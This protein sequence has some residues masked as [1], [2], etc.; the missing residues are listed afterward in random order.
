MWPW[1]S[2]VLVTLPF[3]HGP[4]PT[5]PRFIYATQDFDKQHVLEEAIEHDHIGV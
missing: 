4:A 5:T 1:F 2:C 3:S